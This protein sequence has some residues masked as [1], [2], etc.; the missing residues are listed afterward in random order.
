MQL[1]GDQLVGEPAGEGHQVVGRDRTGDGDTH[2]VSSGWQRG[3]GTAGV[4][5]THGTRRAR[6]PSKT[7]GAIPAVGCH[8]P[9]PKV[10]YHGVA[11]VAAGHPA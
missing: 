6:D 1:L 2:G 5:P 11:L 10:Y 8:P 3:H 4:E 9:P 7:P